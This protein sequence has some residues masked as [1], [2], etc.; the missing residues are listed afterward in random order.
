[1]TVPADSSTASMVIE[2]L[3]GYA[4]FHHIGT[5]RSTELVPV[6]AVFHDDMAGSNFRIHIEAANPAEQST[7]TAAVNVPDRISHMSQDQLMDALRQ[8]A[9]D[10]P[11]DTT[12]AIQRAVYRFPTL[13]APPFK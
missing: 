2:I 3:S 9:A 13:N 6:S 1:M 12:R 7:P 11:D 4:D 5:K 10:H 8:L